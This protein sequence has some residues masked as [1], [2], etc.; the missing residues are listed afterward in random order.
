VEAN[1]EM[2]EPTAC[3]KRWVGILASFQ[4]NLD[5]ITGKHPESIEDIKILHAGL[6]TIGQLIH[7]LPR[8]NGNSAEWKSIITRTEEERTVL[9]KHPEGQALFSGMLR[10]YAATHRDLRNSLKQ[11]ASVETER[12]PTQ[13][14]E[15]FCK[16]KRRKRT[17]TGGKVKN[18]KKTTTAAT[19]PRGLRMQPQGQVST[20]NFFALLRTKDME[21][22]CPIM[23]GSAEKPDGE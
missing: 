19:T 1:T 16:Q 6:V 4:K 5:D 8:V 10:L 9:W 14:T 23:E 11:E 7:S 20:K 22:E 17:P 2:A 15:E 12:D 21:M 3:K 18:Q 13:S